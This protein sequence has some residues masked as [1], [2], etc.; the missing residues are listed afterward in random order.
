VAEVNQVLCGWGAYFR[1]A[2]STRKFQD[3]DGY[4]R[5]RQGKFL[6]KKAGRGGHQRERYTG[7]FFD[8]LGVYQLTGT[9]K[10]YAAAPRATRER[11][12]KPGARTACPV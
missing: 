1:V 6:A 10:W 12:R 8:K 7:V 5:E 4:V 3:V 11:P 9:V 2:N